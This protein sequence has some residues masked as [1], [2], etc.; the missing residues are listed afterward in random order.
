MILS[1]R[2]GESR[3]RQEGFG[4]D[5]M[6]P[7]NPDEMRRIEA[8]EERAVFIACPGFFVVK[9]LSSISQTRNVLM[10]YKLFLILPLLAVLLACSR[11]PEAAKQRLIETGNKYFNNGK[12][13][14]A[15]IIYRRA[16]QKDRRFGEAY[17]HLGLA[18]L[19]LGRV[20]QA[21]RALRRATELQPDNEDAYAQLC[22]LYLLIYLANPA[23]NEKLLGDIQELTDQA[24]KHFP[25]SFEVNRIRGFVELSQQN[26]DM[27]IPLFRRAVEQKPDDGR[28]TLGLA[29][30]LLGAGQKEEAESLARNY[31]EKHPKYAA[32]YDFLYVLY[33]RQNRNDEALE[34]LKRK[35]ANNPDKIEYQLQL[36]RHY[37]LIR[38][39]AAM[40]AVLEELI[41]NPKKYPDVYL[42]VGKFYTQSKDYDKALDLY[43]KGAETFPKQAIQYKQKIAELLAIQGK[44]EEAFR[45]VESI[46]A[47]DKNNSKALA[48]RGA[49]RLKSGDSAEIAAAIADFEAVLNRMPENVVLRYN[50][51]KA[52]LA[53]GNTG[54]AIVEFQT[55]IEKRPDYLPPRRSLVLIYLKRREFAKA[56][57]AVDEILAIRPNDIQAQLIRSNAWIGLGERAKARASLEQ[58]LKEFPQD[59]DIAFHLARLD[60]LDGRYTEAEELFRRLYEGTPPDVRGLYGLAEVYVRQKRPQQALD[61]MHSKIQEEPD[62]LTYHLAMGNIL[63]RMGDYDGAVREIKTVLTKRPDSGGLY[64]TLGETYY[65]AGRLQE[66]EESLKRASE[67]LPKDPAP[68][69]YLGMLA[70]LSGATQQAASY[71]EQSLKLGPDNVIA[72]NNLAYIL[73]ETT[74]DLDRALTLIQ[75]A[76]SR[77]P[78]N[79]DVADTLAW[80]YIKKNLP[81]SAVPILNEIL[82]KKPAQSD[83]RYHLG[84]ALYQKGDTA[85][86]KRELE[87]ALKSNP[88]KIEEGKIRDLLSRL[89]S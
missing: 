12:Y 13:K 18:A 7:Q 46:L 19:K 4:A 44:Q 42:A 29:R 28:V 25:N 89:G 78:N 27:A 68:P 3:V 5:F 88:T 73:A 61:L 39:R 8:R 14:E 43:R 49:L 37:L 38:D 57:A 75:R 6:R 48:M 54:R 41:R 59:R 34:V 82:S 21:T 20:R 71:Y 63:T 67:L 84:M 10:R 80:I 11:D 47:E 69:L 66:A 62:N 58:L 31:I 22:D 64:R 87:A 35:C 76:R 17:Y 65:R 70:E 60:V 74:A 32:V 16:I 85:G 50:L 15:S 51:G 23:K 1:M 36:A 45:V 56:V 2:A 40:K 81:D 72:L 79:L 9:C 33:A 53:Q 86:A 77:A 83:W 30:G 55:A 26:F 52:Y 24:Q